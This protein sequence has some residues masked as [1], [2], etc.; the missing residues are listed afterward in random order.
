[1]SQSATAHDSVAWRVSSCAMPAIAPRIAGSVA[2]RACRQATSARERLAYA[3]LGGVL[4]GN[5]FQVARR[6]PRHSNRGRRHTLAARQRAHDRRV[7]SLVAGRL[8]SGV[9]QPRRRA[10]GGQ[11]AGEDL[12]RVDRRRLELGAAGSHI[13]SAFQP[14]DVIAARKPSGQRPQAMRGVTDTHHGSPSAGTSSHSLMATVIS[15]PAGRGR[16]ARRPFPRRRFPR[17][18]DRKG[19]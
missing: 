10:V 3:T 12:E 13:P 15:R 9:D 7:T 16:A 1:M 5:R 2:T 8:A 6:P 19:R 18:P 14:D 4:E 17:P 11:L